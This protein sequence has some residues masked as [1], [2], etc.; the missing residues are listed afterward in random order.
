MSNA[1]TTKQ[2]TET[3]QAPEPAPEATETRRIPVRVDDAGQAVIR[4][5]ITLRLA[6]L[7]DVASDD[8]ELHGHALAGICGEWLRTQSDLLREGRL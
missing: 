3:K 7:G 5:A 4:R 2:G 1:T 8:P 6:M